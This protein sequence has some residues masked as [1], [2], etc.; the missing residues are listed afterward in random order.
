MNI[1]LSSPKTITVQAAKTVTVTEITVNRVVDN[2]AKQIVVAF[3]EQLNEP[4]ILWS[5]ETYVSIGQWTDTD[6]VNRLTAIYNS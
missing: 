6:V 1:T 2:P 3:I 4:V 5:G